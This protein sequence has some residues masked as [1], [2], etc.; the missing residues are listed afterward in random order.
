MFAV[1][2]SHSFDVPCKQLTS[3]LMWIVN[4]IYSLDV[5][6]IEMYCNS[7]AEPCKAESLSDVYSNYR[8]MDVNNGSLQYEKDLK[9]ST[10][11]KFKDYSIV[12]QYVEV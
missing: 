6:Y 7:S 11:I 4:P 10:I 8:T 1:Y 9:R 5:L 3:I 2:P 12:L